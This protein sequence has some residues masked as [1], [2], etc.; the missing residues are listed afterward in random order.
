MIMNKK[1]ILVIVAVIA[2]VAILVGGCEDK[3]RFSGKF[4]GEAPAVDAVDDVKIKGIKFFCDPSG[5]MKGY[6]DFAGIK[7][8]ESTDI[9]I[10][11]TVSILANRV[12]ELDPKPTFSAKCGTKTWN[13]SDSFV[14]GMRN[15]E[16]FQNGSSF[17]W[18]L[19]DEGV[20]YATDSTVSVILSDMVLSFGKTPILASKDINYNTHRLD[21]LK[22][23]VVS[24][25]TEAFKEQKREAKQGN[26][27]T[28]YTRPRLDV[29]VIQYF[30]D[31]NGK[32]YFNC[33]ENLVDTNSSVTKNNFDGKNM[34]DRPYYMM[35]IGTEA[36]LKYLIEKGC[37][38][39]HKDMNM[40]ATFV[41]DNL[42]LADKEYNVEYEDTDSKNKGIWEKG[43]DKGDKAVGG[44]YLKFI[45]E[46][47]VATSFTIACN[48]FKLAPYYYRNEEDFEAECEGYA[49]VSD[50]KYENNTLTMRLTTEPIK[51]PEFGKRGAF[52]INIFAKN[53]WVESSSCI[54]DVCDIENFEPEDSKTK[55]QNRLEDLEGKT[56]GLKTLFDGI[57]SVYYKEQPIEKV[58]VGSLKIQYQYQ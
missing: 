29:L 3:P 32:Y 55:I 38:E 58:K 42:T 10:A 54:D 45:P 51:K 18:E 44:F 39:K 52:S 21:G 20:K 25:M 15:K 56:W 30:S 46:D 16:V 31:F 19:M 8:T 26:K 27:S 14:A 11:S 24:R 5:S 17:V 48:D 28:I 35:F 22:A 2:V 6:T 50:I 37:Y 33:K 4:V 53:N 1:V 12:S 7:V 40:Y 9:N 41:A 13:N 36:N 34:K 43:N 57:N 49:S 23:E 47:T